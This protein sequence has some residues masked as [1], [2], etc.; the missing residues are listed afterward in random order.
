MSYALSSNTLPPLGPQTCSLTN[1]ADAA[2]AC[3]QSVRSY[4]AGAL[5]ENTH[6]AYYSDLEH[7]HA[8]GGSIPCVPAVVAEYLAAHACI[9]CVATLK[10]RLATIAKAHRIIG[11]ETPTR[12]ELVRATL[13]GIQRKHGKPQRRA[14]PLTRELLFKVL[15]AMGTDLKASRDAALLLIGFA[16]AFRRSEL[17]CLRFSDIDWLEGGILV[18]LPRSKTDQ[19]R[20]GRRIAIPNGKTKWCPVTAL[21]A[22]LTRARITEGPLFRPIEGQRQIPH[23]RLSGEA[24]S[25]LIKKRVTAAGLDP[26]NFSGHSLRAGFAT[27]ASRAD[28]ASW[29]IREQTG[30]R[31]DQM[32]TRYIRWTPTFSDNPN[33]ELL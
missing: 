30:H 29:K 4:V 33:C 12:A 1:I 14:K 27:S 15:E 24:I 10:R 17:C 9:N 19:E 22:W 21:Q 7:F 5:S 20:I 2:S 11:A 3:S 31:S 16:G 6:R 18:H 26:Q 8:W 23:E 28:V 32:L 25:I 13:R